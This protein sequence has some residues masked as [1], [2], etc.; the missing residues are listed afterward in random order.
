VIILDTGVIVSSIGTTDA[1]IVAVAERLRIDAVATLDS[2][3]RAV[4]PKHVKGFRL[5]PDDL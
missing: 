3:F 5:L 4:R 1:T 2:H